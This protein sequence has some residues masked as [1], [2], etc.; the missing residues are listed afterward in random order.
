MACR[1]P[2]WLSL[3]WFF[4]AGGSGAQPSVP[5]AGAFPFPTAAPCAGANVVPDTVAALAGHVARVTEALDAREPG[6]WRPLRNLAEAACSAGDRAALAAAFERCSRECRDVGDR[7]LAH[8]DYASTLERFG[9]VAGAE[10]EYLAAIALRPGRPP[11]AIEAYNRYALLLDRQGRPQDALAV[12]DR[13]TAEELG[14]HSFPALLR[15]WVMRELGMVTPTV[16]PPI[17]PGG[18]GSPTGIRSPVG[19]MG[20][21]PPT[22]EQVAIEP[23][24][25]EVLSEVVVAPRRSPVG[26]PSAEPGRLEFTRMGT[27]D[28]SVRP[29]ELTLARGEVFTVVA[30]LGP[31]GCRIEYGPA[32]YDLVACPWRRAAPDRQRDFYRVLGRRATQR[33]LADASSLASTQAPPIVAP[34]GSAPPPTEADSWRTFYRGVELAARAQARA[35]EEV[36]AERAPLSG[37]EAAAAM[38]AARDFL[39][40]IESIDEGARAELAARFGSPLPPFGSAMLPGPAGDGARPRALVPAVTPDGRSV[41]EVLAAEGFMSRI[42]AAKTAALAAHR[43]RLDAALGAARAARVAA[44]VPI[45]ADTA[46][47]LRGPRGPATLLQTTQPRTAPT[48]AADAALVGAMAPELDAVELGGVRGAQPLRAGDYRFERDFDRDGR[49]ELVLVGRHSGDRTF[50]LIA[51]LSGNRWQ[52]VALFSFAVPELRGQ[53]SV[54]YPNRLE[55]LFCAACDVGGWLEW[56]GRDYEFRSSRAPGEAGAIPAAKLQGLGDVLGVHVGAVGE[57]GERARDLEHTQRAARRQL[58]AVGRA[59]Q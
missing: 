32:N 19:L 50:A 5:A 11:E 31:E 23:M 53:A 38:A 49:L 33:A 21:L 43:A 25:V 35:A 47:A 27:R 44:A 34:F 12:L 59:L 40:A 1:P 8:L 39:A 36:L 28:P 26:P 58:P 22:P 48:S 14:R 10:R 13:F 46:S 30:E 9:D 16:S 18:F 52:R 37:A 20:G 3:V 55:V 54:L 15:A 2:S 6:L 4:I 45:A 24:A 51:T 7:Y 57:V 17:A 41:Q 29:G 42:A 56:T